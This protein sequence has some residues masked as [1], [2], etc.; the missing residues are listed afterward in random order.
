MNINRKTTISE[1]GKLANTNRQA[2]PRMTSLRKI[3]L[4]AGVLYLLTFVSIPIGVLY[5]PIQRSELHRRPWPGHWRHLRRRPGDHRGP[6]RHRH[7][8]RA[9]PGGQ[10]AERRGRAGLRRRAGPGSRHDLR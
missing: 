10:E 3:A 7:R 1:G 6:R 9:V 8:R 4:A 5:A 2:A